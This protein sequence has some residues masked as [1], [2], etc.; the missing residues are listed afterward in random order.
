MS[1]YKGTNAVF[2]GSMCVTASHGRRIKG[3][4]ESE[5]VRGRTHSSLH[6]LDPDLR[7]TQRFE[8]SG[9]NMT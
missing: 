5:G 3:P 6:H 9:V 1:Q 4:G 8:T 2:T 7:S